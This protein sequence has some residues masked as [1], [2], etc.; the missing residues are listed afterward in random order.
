VLAAVLAAAAISVPKRAFA[1]QAEIR[2]RSVVQ[3]EAVPDAV[4]ATDADLVALA[5]TPGQELASIDAGT[6]T[7]F[8]AQWLV[9]RLSRSNPGIQFRFFRLNSI[10]RRELD[11]D[12]IVDGKVTARSAGGYSR[13]ARWSPSNALDFKLPL[14]GWTGSEATVLI[15]TVTTERLPFSPSF[16]KDDADPVRD[17]FYQN[18]AFLFLG[19]TLAFISV[20]LLVFLALHDR[21]S[22]D[23][24]LFA[25]S[26][27]LLSWP[28]T[29]CAFGIS[30][31]ARVPST[32]LTSS[33]C[34]G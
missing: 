24:T 30:G 17:F 28:A 7:P 8:K 25:G 29:G 33:T 18:F 11:A 27:C 10:Q 12:L 13:V 1:Q 19:C 23:F 9:L 20:H 31:P 16:R 34:S 14:G 26:T 15:R 2:I 4:P 3:L 32:S 22:R 6:Y 5:N 21:A